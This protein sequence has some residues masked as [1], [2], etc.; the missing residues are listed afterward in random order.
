M[1]YVANKGYD[2]GWELGN[3]PDNLGRFGKAIDAKRLGRDFV[4]LREILN[5]NPKYG[6]FMVGP[7]LTRPKNNSMEF[8][9]EFLSVALNAVDAITWHHWMDKLGLAARLGAEI[10]VK[11]T[12][13]HGNYALVD[14]GLN[15]TPNYWLS[16]L[17]KRFVGQKV[18]NVKNGLDEKRI[19][20]VYAHCTDT[21]SGQYDR[22]AVTV[23][24]LNLSPISDVVLTLTGT[25]GDHRVDQYLLTPYQDD[26]TS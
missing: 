25:L 18:L 2:F 23:M 9:K 14:D 10:A 5:K 17:H 19:V 12:F 22:G 20:R 1:Q 7:D 11:Q 26:L 6:K 13:F 8:L 16:L 24:V 4:T 3:E 21:K 15:P